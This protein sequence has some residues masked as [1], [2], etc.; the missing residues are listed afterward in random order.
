MCHDQNT[1]L[2]IM[3]LPMC[4]LVRIPGVRQDLGEGEGHADGSVVVHVLL[5]Q[6]TRARLSA[7][8]AEDSL[9]P[10][11]VA[12]KGQTPF[13]GF[14]EYLPAFTHALTHT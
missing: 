5:I 2:I 11:T 6:K 3:H 8:I 12:P 10:V 13:P 14:Q 9:L 1:I 4:A 7:P